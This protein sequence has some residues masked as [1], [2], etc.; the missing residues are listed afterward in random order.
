MGGG[1]VWAIRRGSCGFVQ[2]RDQEISPLLIS[3]FIAY[4]LCMY[5]GNHYDR[6]GGDMTGENVDFQEPGIKIVFYVEF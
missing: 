5:T 4:Q 3:P 2:Y 1:A 6:G